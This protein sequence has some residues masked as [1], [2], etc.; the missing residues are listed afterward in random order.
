M[1]YLLPEKAYQA[2][3]WLGLIAAPAIGLFY[4]VVAPKWGWPMPEA[5]QT[6]LDAL[7]VLIGTLIGVS[8]ATAEEVP[9]GDA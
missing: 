8:Q 1:K 2:L 5:V 4:A 3:K 7:G 6:T 9:D